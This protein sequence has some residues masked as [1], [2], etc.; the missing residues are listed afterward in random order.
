MSSGP[1][2]GQTNHPH[3]SCT[4]TGRS[5][6]GLAVLLRRTAAAR[7]VAAVPNTAKATQ[8]SR[9]CVPASSAT[10]TA[11]AT[12]QPVPHEIAESTRPWLSRG[13]SRAT[14]SANGG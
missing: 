1:E 10:G 7:A 2:R 4:A 12:P 11:S 6:G 9:Q 5:S 14:A 13:T 8:A 3:D